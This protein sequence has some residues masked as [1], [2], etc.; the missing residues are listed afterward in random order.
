MVWLTPILVALIGGPLMVFLK[1]F[2]HKNSA[3]HGESLKVLER[4]EGK[5]DK[6]DNRLDEHILWHLDRPRSKEGAA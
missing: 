6:V 5:V 1:R 4:I 2:E 3:Q